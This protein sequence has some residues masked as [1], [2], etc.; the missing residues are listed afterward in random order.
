MTGEAMKIHAKRLLVKMRVY[1]V[2]HIVL[3]IA[4]VMLFSPKDEIDTIVLV[5]LVFC[6]IFNLIMSLA[7][8]QIRHLQEYVCTMT[9]VL[10]EKVPEFKNAMNDESNWTPIRKEDSE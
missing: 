4:L 1:C 9:C 5:G 8:A 2:I 3:M 6:V 7:C 10:A